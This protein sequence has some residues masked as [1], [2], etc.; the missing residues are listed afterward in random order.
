MNKKRI[1]HFIKELRREKKITQKELAHRL[2]VFERT[3]SCWEKG[4]WM[5][6]IYDLELLSFQLDITIN[7]LLLGEK[8]ENKNDDTIFYYAMNARK[9]KKLLFFFSIVI[10][11]IAV[12]FVLTM[13][14]K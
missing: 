12:I 8:L 11:L 1:G 6:S 4:L 2:G 10:L 13:I 3:I 14:G 7:E 9:R 5:P